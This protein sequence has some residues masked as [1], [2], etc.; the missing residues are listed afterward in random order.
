MSTKRVVRQL[1]AVVAADVA[2][3]SRLMAADEEGTLADM[4]SHRRA[5]IDPKI[6]QHRGRIVKTTGDGMLLEFAS[7]VDAVRC[8]VDV[9]RGMI[10]R[11][12]T[13]AQEKRIEFRIGINVGDII[14]DDGDI[15]GDGVNVAA[16][17]EGIAEPGGIFISR[18]VF[19]QVDGKLALRVRKLGSRNL[20]NIAKP[21]EVFAI[22]QMGRSDEAPERDRAEQPIQKVKYC[23]A[24][25]GVRL[26]YAISGSGPILVKSANW[27]NHLEYDWESPIW[28][29]VFRGLSRDHTLIRYDARGNGMS[30]W[31]VDELS[32]DAW[33]SDLETIVDAAG[34]QRFPLLGMSQGCAISVAYAVRYP[35]RV[36]HLVLYG[37]F[38]LGGKKRAPAEKER[39]NAMTT[40]MRL[41]WGADNPSFRQMFTGL[42]IPG[43]THE[44]ADI[45]NE[46]Q[47]RTTSPECAARYFDVVGDFDITHRLADVKVP[48]LVMHARGDLMVPIEAG[49]QLAAG[50]PGARFIAFEGQN[51]LF[52]EHEP[53]SDRF[54][55]EIRLFLSG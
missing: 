37:G 31:D 55:E 10:A 8:A 12:E 6:R 16:R 36:S 42:F 23:R 45:F 28:R 43:G 48:T 53:A 13:V 26:A 49:R 11:N 40:L 41:G 38:A 35:E 46:L 54:F 5:L 27:M 21:V 29:H 7:V 3:Y 14:I 44:Q 52:L 15:Y 17:L 22:D 32:L 47:R 19:D 51:H 39:R 4:K 50:I 18:Q 33:V 9:Q 2:G 24:P 20:K 30:D 1:M 34:V 25:D